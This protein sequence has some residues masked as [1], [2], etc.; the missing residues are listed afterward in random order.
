[1]IT[2]S[3]VHP[4][5]GVT[6]HSTVRTSSHP[7]G[8]PPLRV[9]ACAA[10]HAACAPFTAH[11][12]LAVPYSRAAPCLTRRALP[13]CRCVGRL[14]LHPHTLGRH[15]QALPCLTPEP[16]PQLW[17]V[18]PRT[19]RKTCV[20]VNNLGSVMHLHSLLPLHFRRRTRMPVLI[21]AICPH[22]PLPLPHCLL[23]LPLCRTARRCLQHR[24][25][26]LRH[27]ASK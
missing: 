18:T 24:A 2:L 20:N 17:N 7:R 21:T 1:M 23:P 26:A 22:T 15:E 11:M 13:R 25:R 5:A 6:Y 19:R 16:C 12:R 4:S 27:R 3:G 10:A 9:P 8:M 14:N